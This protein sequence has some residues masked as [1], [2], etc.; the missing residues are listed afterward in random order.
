MQGS[1]NGGRGR[2][3]LRGLRGEIADCFN[4]IRCRGA[5]IGELTGDAERDVDLGD[6]FVEV[7]EQCTEKCSQ[8]AESDTAA[9]VA[10]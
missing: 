8:Q 3:A 1:E 10:G 6:K 7:I 4:L 2:C 5:G 9:A